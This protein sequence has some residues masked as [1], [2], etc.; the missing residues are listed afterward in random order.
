MPG[1]FVAVSPPASFQEQAS[2]MAGVVGGV[3]LSAPGVFP[4]AL[5]KAISHE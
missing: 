1:A 2:S 5:L 3:C 4:G